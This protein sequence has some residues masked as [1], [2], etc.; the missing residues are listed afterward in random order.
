MK[1]GIVIVYLVLWKEILLHLLMLCLPCKN[2]N[3]S[4]NMEIISQSDW[5]KHI[6]QNFENWYDNNFEAETPK[7]KWFQI[8]S[9]D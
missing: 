1:F 7:T 3:E 5:V 6:K 4:D 2:F 9:H 8:K